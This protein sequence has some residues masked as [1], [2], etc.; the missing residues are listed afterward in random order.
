MTPGLVSQWITGRTVITAERAAQIELSTNGAVTR[1]ELRPD[2]F[3]PLDEI[4]D[5]GA[6]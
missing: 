6:T 2:I 4:R 5:R 3:G 1:A